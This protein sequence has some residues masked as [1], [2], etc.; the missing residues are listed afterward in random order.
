M[1]AMA[2]TLD[3]E[4][5]ERLG[6]RG[7]VAGYGNLAVLHDVSITVPAGSVTAVIGPNGAG[8]TT[9]MSAVFGL[10]HVM[11]GEVWF[12]K[13]EITH[14]P[15][16]RIAAMGIGYVPQTGNVFPG[17][18]VHENMEMAAHQL[19]KSKELA[20]Q[21]IVAAYDMF[22]RLKQ[23]RKQKASSLSGGERQMLA[24]AS[25]QMMKPSLLILDEPTTGLAPQLVHEVTERIV[26]MNQAGMTILW[27]VEENPLDVLSVADSVYVL[28]GGAVKSHK[29]GRDML[30][31]PN[32]VSMF[33]G[34]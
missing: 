16:D 11:E 24:I 5:E 6:V 3:S 21:A 20:E 17:L 33:L 13:R 12:E 19:R 28:E 32:L 8:K 29:S 23:R 15:A 7:L 26:S 10:I 9:L 4:A 25:A 18:T 2:V 27:V 34:S 30:S 14:S 1:E 22:P 31:D